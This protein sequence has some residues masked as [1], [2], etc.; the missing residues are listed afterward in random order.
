MKGDLY[1]YPAKLFVYQVM[2]LGTKCGSI[3]GL[4]WLKG[5][6][7]SVPNTDGLATVIE[8]WATWCPPCRATIPVGP[9]IESL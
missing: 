9:N 1:S 8:F 2:V 7:I 3:S 6:P 5:G 4:T